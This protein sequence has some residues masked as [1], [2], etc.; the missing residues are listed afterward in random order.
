MQNEWMILIINL[1]G[2]AEVLKLLSLFMG[3]EGFF[4]LPKTLKVKYKKGVFI[5]SID[6]NRWLL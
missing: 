3:D 5:P 2:I 4:Y 6:E 1:G